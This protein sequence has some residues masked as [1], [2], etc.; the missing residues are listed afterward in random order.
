MARKP[1]RKKRQFVFVRDLMDEV[2]NGSDSWNQTVPK[3]RKRVDSK[4]TDK[5][6]IF[7]MFFRVVSRSFKTLSDYWNL[8]HYYQQK[9]RTSCYHFCWLLNLK[10]FHF[11]GKIPPIF[12]PK[13]TDKKATFVHTLLLPSDQKP[14]HRE[15]PE[16]MIMHLYGP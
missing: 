11:H 1:Q 2:M 16:I 8:N 6:V 10:S 4:Q 3:P 7:C 15:Q 5:L 9:K 13:L 12:P 14:V